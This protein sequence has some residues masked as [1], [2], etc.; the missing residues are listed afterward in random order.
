[1]SVL[2]GLG[3]CKPPPLCHL[4]LFIGLGCSVASGTGATG[5]EKQLTR[6]DVA[7]SAL[8]RQDSPYVK[9]FTVCNMSTGNTLKHIGKRC[10]LRSSQD[11]TYAR[12]HQDAVEAS[13][14]DPDV[15][16]VVVMGHSYGGFVASCIAEAL[17]DHPYAH[18]LH[19]ATYGAIQV[20]APSAVRNINMVQFMN[21]NDV[22]L[23]CNGLADPSSQHRARSANP[24]AD[25]LA[26][27]TISVAGGGDVV[28]RS[29]SPMTWRE[30]RT[31]V[32]WSVS[33]K[34]KELSTLDR[35]V[36]VGT[37]TE[38]LIHN[39]YCHMRDARVVAQHFTALGTDQC[40]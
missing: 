36:L 1:M 34:H 12:M 27:L 18:K 20:A 32:V 35:M 28:L 25:P 30:W 5:E 11:T 23:R 39:D 31:G 26:Q 3:P 38:W 10:V 40:G 17:N 8:A 22:A 2:V 9:T 6:G 21:V 24:R 4:Y 14:V 16:H 15:T 7:R 19:V 29:D 37:P 33:S 13:L